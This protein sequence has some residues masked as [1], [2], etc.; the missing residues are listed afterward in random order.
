[1]NKN[2]KEFEDF[3]K[4]IQDDK[5]ILKPEQEKPACDRCRKLL[6]VECICYENLA[7]K[8]TDVAETVQSG[9]PFKNLELTDEDRELLAKA[10][11]V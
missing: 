3:E 9:N 11:I 7:N 2:Q 6:P 5:Y 10:G 4:S 1:M 8:L